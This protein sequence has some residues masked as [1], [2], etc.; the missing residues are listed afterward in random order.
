MFKTNLHLYVI[1]LF[2]SLLLNFQHRK[3]IRGHTV[4]HVESGAKLSPAA[5][6]NRTVDESL[7]AN[8]TSLSTPE[9]GSSKIVAVCTR[10][11]S[12]RSVVEV[13]RSE[14]TTAQENV[15]S[16]IGVEN[17]A[18]TES[19]CAGSNIIAAESYGAEN[20]G[21]NDVLFISCSDASTVLETEA[22]TSSAELITMHGADN[23]TVAICSESSS[24][25]NPILFESSAP[26]YQDLMTASVQTSSSSGTTLQ[27]DLT[28]ISVSSVSE[29]NSHAVTSSSTSESSAFVHQDLT[30]TAPNSANCTVDVLDHVEISSITSTLHITPS[31]PFVD[32][33]TNQLQMAL[34]QSSEL[35]RYVGDMLAESFV[36]SIGPSQIVSTH[37][38][39]SSDAL[40]ET[41]MKQ[42]LP[43]EGSLPDVTVLM[44]NVLCTN[45][46]S[47]IHHFQNFLLSM[48]YLTM[49][50]MLLSFVK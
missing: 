4:L 16:P 21:V 33:S 28:A 12:T 35:N 6:S 14:A 3:D 8:R 1:Q 29:A 47:F 39:I 15:C 38:S 31:A 45:Y 11:D 22:R 24:I 49:H 25:S 46:H 23:A 26:F 13:Y 32:S 43:A 18:A 40:K 37:A 41:R 27:R 44:P 50:V 42:R 34:G 30:A 10:H 7:G 17:S 48:D 20:L 5:R 19:S 9:P 36:S 2:Y